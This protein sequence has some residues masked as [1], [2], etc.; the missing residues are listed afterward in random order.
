[1]WT[2]QKPNRLQQILMWY[3]GAMVWIDVAATA[4]KRKP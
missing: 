4:T 3:L 2:A 1:M